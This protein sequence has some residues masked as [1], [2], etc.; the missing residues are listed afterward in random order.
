MSNDPP[1][2][3]SPAANADPVETGEGAASNGA[4]DADAD[5]IA[6]RLT[7]ELNRVD[8]DRSHPN[9]RPRDAATLIVIDRSGDAPKVLLG[10]RHARHKFL[11]G[12][13]VFPGGRVE[14]TDRI[15]NAASEL[16]PQVAARLMVQTQRPSIA[17]ARAFAIAAIR[18]TFEETGLIFGQ[19]IGELPGAT[20][21]QL[22]P[23]A[24]SR[25]LPDLT[26]MHFIAR[27]VTPPRRPRRFDTRFFALDANAI[28]GQVEGV[29]GPDAELIELVW[30]PLTEAERLDMPPITKVVLGE[31][32]LRIAAGFTHDLPAPFYRWIGR[33]F[34][35]SL[36]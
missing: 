25:L 36:L 18:E 35:R 10:L 32:E 31:L 8:R 12:K 7:D 2:N 9:L 14:P 4:V 6:R 5:E 11:P 27:A 17:K 34:T 23:S 29:V 22:P 20:G 33:G 28:T 21:G 16:D 3:R 15:A 24:A 1:D 13:F 26:A 19:P 30:L